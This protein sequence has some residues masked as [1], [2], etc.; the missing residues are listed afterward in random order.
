MTYTELRGRTRS[1]GRERA[2]GRDGGNGMD[3]VCAGAGTEGSNGSIWAL[4]G[5][6]ASGLQ[7]HRHASRPRRRAGILYLLVPPEGPRMLVGP[8]TEAVGQECRRA[9][10]GEMT[11]P[12]RLDT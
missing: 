8:A 3:Q 9:R 6:R 2:K 10:G 11:S 4:L 7:G 5:R 12:R 1:T